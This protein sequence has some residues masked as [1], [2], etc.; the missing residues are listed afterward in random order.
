MKE[1]T[2]GVADS[3]RSFARLQSFDRVRALG[4]AG[5]TF[6]SVGATDSRQFSNPGE[7]LPTIYQ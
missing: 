1:R 3:W 5:R 6:R 2:T 4:C 7:E